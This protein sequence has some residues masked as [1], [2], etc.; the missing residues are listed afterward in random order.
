[1][2]SGQWTEVFNRSSNTWKVQGQVFLSGEVES[3]RG[4]AEGGRKGVKEGGREGRRKRGGGRRKMVS[5]CSGA[6]V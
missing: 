4:F 3:G 1:M 5:F 2:Y 6:K